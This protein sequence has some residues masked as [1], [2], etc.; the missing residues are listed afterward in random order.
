MPVSPRL[1]ALVGFPALLLLAGVGALALR[2]ASREPI[3]IVL[4][5]PPAT[6]SPELKVYVSGSVLTPGVYLFAPGDRVEDAV[7]A[8]GGA[9]ADAELERLNLA[10][11]LRDADH[12]FVPRRGEPLPSGKAGAPRTNIN[13]APLAALDALPGIGTT[14]ARRIIESRTNEGLFLDPWELVERRIL[15]ASVYQQV[16]DLISVN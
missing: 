6:V 1:L 10:A 15:P 13:T 11:K 3:Q 12:V 9:T 7:R 14:R 5:T 8:A 2:P 16:K 4:P